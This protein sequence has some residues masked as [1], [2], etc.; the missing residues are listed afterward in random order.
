MDF[1][2]AIE[3]SD[4]KFV[5]VDKKIKDEMRENF[6]EIINT[7]VDISKQW[8]DLLDYYLKIGMNNPPNIFTVPIPVIERC[9]KEVK[10][11][12]EKT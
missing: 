9:F 2:D 8:P 4:L 3:K 1:K 10:E 12:F 5:D 6:L 11:E 7:G